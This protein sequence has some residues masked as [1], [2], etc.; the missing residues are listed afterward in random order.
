MAFFASC[1]NKLENLQGWK[2]CLLAF[3]LGL[4]SAL[5]FP[6]FNLIPVLWITFPVLLV[7]L[8]GAMH[9]RTTFWLG[10]S[11]SFGILTIS[12]YWISASLFVDIQSFWW[13]LP[14]AIAGLPAALS[15]Y[16]G[17]ATLLVWFWGPNR[18]DAPFFF[19]LVWFVAELARAHLFTGFPWDILGYVWGDC[20]PV[21]QSVSL[22]GVDGLTFVTLL[23]AVLPVYFV[24]L[25]SR[26]KAFGLVGMGVLLI[27]G[28]AAWGQVRLSLAPYESVPAVRLRLV[29]PSHNQAM[30]WKA[31]QRVQ[32]FS[33]LLDLTFS[34]AGEKPVTHYVWPETATA[35]YLGEEEGVRK[36]IAERMN[37]GSVLLTGVISRAFF[38]RKPTQ[39]YN[40]MVAMDDK[41]NVI[42][43]YDKHHLVPFGEYMPFRK[44]VS[45]PAIAMMGSDF[46]AGD[47]LRTLRVPNLL[48]F[49]PLVCYEAIFSGAVVEREDPPQF[50]LNVT[51]DAWYEGTIGPD[52]H[53]AIAR[54]RAVEEG[55]PLVRVANKG[56]TGVVDGWGR[57]WASIGADESSFIDSDLPVASST[58]TP[59]SVLGFPVAALL[60]GIVSIFL[61]CSRALIRTKIV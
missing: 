10:W 18:D 48:P 38:E 49:S 5:A 19:A 43:G 6:P 28:A 32:N 54:V 12:L 20:L 44:L 52:Q 57:V 14:F 22:I 16:Y 27:A 30:K 3:V 29:Q 61:F 55:L 59:V 11:F 26:R 4:L 21:L 46:T 17:L 37:K 47:G 35:Y 39:Y 15:F 45:V 36:R 33:H 51:N 60:I 53:F 24:I 50:L 1:V 40:S 23:V 58:N 41:G 8:R 25:P 31:E 56:I 2:A 42:A 34:Q 9:A 7:L 13:A